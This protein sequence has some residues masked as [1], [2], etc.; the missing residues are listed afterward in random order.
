M[1]RFLK[2]ALPLLLLLA[3]IGY[4]IYR[5]LFPP[6]IVDEIPNP[7]RD[8]ATLSKGVDESAIPT[9]SLRNLF[10]G[11]LH[12]HTT[13]SFDAYI[14][15]NRATPADAYRFAKG[16]EIEIF[17][18]KVKINRPLDFAAVTDH[19]EFLGELYSV[20]TE[21]VPGHQAFYARYFRSL[22]L[23]TI[24]QR[25]LFQRIA[26]RAGQTPS[27]LPFFQGFETTK[28]AWEIELEAAEQHYEPG[29]FTTFAAYEWTSGGATQH[30]HRNIIFR[31]MKVP[32]YP[33][34]ALEARDGESILSFLDQI[35]RQGA[36]VLAIPHNTNLSNGGGFAEKT[37]EYALL[38]HQ[39]EP[40][41]EVHQA[42]GNSEV[43]ARFWQNDEFADFENYA[44]TPT[45]ESNY[46]R[47]ALKQ[48]LRQKAKYGVN[49]HKY[50]LIGSSDTHNSIPGNTEEWG[51]FIGNHTLL[52]INAQLR[53]SRDWILEYGKGKKVYDAINPGG[54][55]AVWAKA[56][57]RGHIY[58]ALKRRE[59]YATSGGRIR[60]RFFAG[61]DFK[62]SYDNN[63]ALV[64]DGYASGV[65]MGSDL[66]KKLDSTTEKQ[67]VPS[68]LAYASKDPEGANLDR[69]QVIKGWYKDGQLHEKIFNVA[70]SDG[71]V[72]NEDGTVPDNGASVNQQT[73]QW[74][75]T[76]GDTELQTVWTDPEF[77]PSTSAFYYLR[78]LEN[79]TA[80]YTLWD[81]IRH[82]VKYPDHIPLITR[83]RAWSSPIWYS[84]NE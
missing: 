64:A 46:V 82:G 5:V 72:L 51:E 68:F 37:K 78:I 41:V 29:K 23:D 9:N 65:P 66:P 56:N 22:G 33:I 20:H 6:M 75:K 52:D 26:D 61:Y 17:E 18:K 10:F 25:E 4:F 73:G 8:R 58:D 19:A 59:A 84:P 81:Q 34:S 79:P 50:G 53:A 35:T 36:Q 60:V 14:G 80:R 63:E 21:G 12:V 49:P 1:S 42:K 69:I 15:G 55:V 13:L 47:D 57:T 30:I 2:I 77:D 62:G 44:Y 38:R 32:D 43:H 48:G 45:Q 70:L 3:L 54:L 24:K 74:D 11:D 27:H 28:S 83:E 67:A 16:K 31:D 76:K 39:Y 40:L 7:I 71:R